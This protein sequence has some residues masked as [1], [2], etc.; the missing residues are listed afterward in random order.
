MG[1]HTLGWVVG[2]L[3]GEG[4]GPRLGSAQPSILGEVRALEPLAATEGAW[5]S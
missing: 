4:Q 5:G 1:R 3:M 2:G